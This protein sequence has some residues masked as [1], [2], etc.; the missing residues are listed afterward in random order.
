MHLHV[1]SAL[2]MKQ[3]TE[4]QTLFTKGARNELGYTPLAAGSSYSS[5]YK[6]KIRS[7]SAKC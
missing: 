4:A 6:H 7:Y 3:N 5:C 2:T 1:Y